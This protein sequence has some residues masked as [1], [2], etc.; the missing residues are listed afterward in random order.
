MEAEFKEEFG[1][2][3]YY[4]GSV[5]FTPSSVTTAMLW[6]GNKVKQQ[7]LK[8]LV[9]LVSPVLDHLWNDPVAENLKKYIF[10]DTNLHE[11]IE[12]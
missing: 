8:T 12:E 1:T 2:M 9:N 11:L 4:G 7:K 3:R 6:D 10:I 5:I